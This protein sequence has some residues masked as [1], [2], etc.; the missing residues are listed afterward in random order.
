[1]VPDFAFSALKKDD[2]ELLKSINLLINQDL[3][4]EK[5]SLKDLTKKNTEMINILE[6]PGKRFEMYTKQNMI[7]ALDQIEKDMTRLHVLLGNLRTKLGSK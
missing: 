6:N 4:G 3:N 2:L 5:G 1:M 7:E